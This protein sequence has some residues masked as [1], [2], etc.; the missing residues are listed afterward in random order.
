MKRLL[1]LLLVL[2]IVISAPTAQAASHDLASLIKATNDFLGSLDA[3]QRSKATFE[4]KAD[5]RM[6]WH[7]VPKSRKG[8][9]LKDMNDAQKELA[10]GLLR[11]TLSQMGYTK[12]ETIRNL[13]EV[14]RIM[15]G[16]DG[17]HRDLEAYYLSVF[18]EPSEKRAVGT[19]V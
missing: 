1:L 14:L 16:R 2:G 15:E 18:G 5:E 13:E 11:T 4:F 10:Q 19:A 12:A 7:F 8:I 6:N 9:S 17:S 3:G